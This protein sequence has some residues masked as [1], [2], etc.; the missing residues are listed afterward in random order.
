MTFPTPLDFFYHSIF[1]KKLSKIKQATKVLWKRWFVC[2]FQNITNRHWIPPK[3]LPLLNA[4]RTFLF[5]TPPFFFPLSSHFPFVF[6]CL[7]LWPGKNEPRFGPLPTRTCS[8]SYSLIRR[9]RQTFPDSPARDTLPQPPPTSADH[10]AQ[11]SSGPNVAGWTIPTLTDD[12]PAVTESDI[13][14]KL[15]HPY[16]AGPAQ[17]VATSA[18]SN[19]QVS[20]R[21]WPATASPTRVLPFPGGPGNHPH[22]LIQNN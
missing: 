6:S 10:A 21:A 5:P 18:S 16:M 14:F 9:Q 17:N 13:T 19:H 20:S 1:I 7:R 2:H 11:P 15:D 22:F 3:H 4:N 12:H 8:P